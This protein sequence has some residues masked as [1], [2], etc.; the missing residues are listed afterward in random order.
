MDIRMYKK[1]FKLKTKPF[2]LMPDLDFLFLSAKHR[3]AISCMEF[4]VTEDIGVIL[5][6]GETGTG[7]TTLIR[8]ILK[9]VKNDID[10]A[11]IY[12]TDVSSEQLL[13]SI[14]QEFGLDSSFE[15]K[16]QAVK[17]LQAHLKS[18]R[19]LKRK[20]LLIIDDAQN[21]SLEA[22]EEIRLLS[23]LQNSVRMLI[24]IILVGQLELEAKLGDPNA[25][26]LAQRVSISYHLLPFSREETEE[27]IVHRLKKAGGQPTLFTQAGLDLIYSTTRGVP[28]AINLLC[29][30]A[31]THAFSI[32]A[33]TIDAPCIKDVLKEN[34]SRGIRAGSSVQKKATIIPNNTEIPQ[35]KQTD[36][37]DNPSDWQADIMHRM[38]VLERLVSTNKK[39]FKIL[40][41]KE[42]Q[43]NDKLLLAYKNLKNKYD[44]LK[45]E[46]ST[47][48]R[49]Q[50]SLPKR[51][52]LVHPISTDMRVAQLVSQKNR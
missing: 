18:L 46:L 50:T 37:K 34:H 9:G 35:S 14:M 51:K 11:T 33:L 32:K 12:N 7:K 52:S 25:S 47:K 27:Y 42:R 24:Q 4:G 22:L 36:T 44:D 48:K 13:A 2:N 17:T 29:D 49:M 45:K 21:L 31:M 23:N 19:M 39:E 5:L 38:D 3:E 1:Y 6:T 40:L 28:R 41:K 26:S 30:N 43:R 16:A 20:P 15:N 8:H 10:V